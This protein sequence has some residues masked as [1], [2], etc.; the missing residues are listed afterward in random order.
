M[1]GRLK[2]IN[3][4]ILK[5]VPTKLLMKMNDGDCVLDVIGKYSSAY[6][7]SNNLVKGFEA[8][9]LITRKKEGRKNIIHLTERGNKVKEHLL[10]IRGLLNEQKNN[11]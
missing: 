6:A 10:K 5:P 7:H 11:L 3:V 2:R 9:G 8:N 1:K 4:A